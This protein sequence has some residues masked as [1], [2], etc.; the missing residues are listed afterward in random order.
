MF[1]EE[2]LRE[3]DLF[4]LEKSGFKGELIALPGRRLW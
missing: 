4:N 2:Q 1:Y 3:L